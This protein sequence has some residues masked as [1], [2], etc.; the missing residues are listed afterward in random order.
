MKILS[1]LSVIC[2]IASI[3]PAVA[4]EFWLAPVEYTIATN[5]NIVVDLRVGQNFDGAAFAFI[6][7]HFVRF[8]AVLGDKV[9]PV[10]SRIGDRPALNMTLP[11]AGL[12][13]IVHETTDRRLTYQD[14]DKFVQF[15]EHKGFPDVLQ[16][17]AARNLPQ[18]DFRE[19]Y[20]RFVK[21]LIAV[22][23]G[24]GMDRDMGLRT[25]IIALANP[26]TDDLTN[27][28]PVI[29]MFEGAPRTNVQLEIFDRAPSGDVTIS[30]Q[31]TDNQ[32]QAV[33]PVQSGHE[34]NLDAVTMLPLP[35]NDPLQD[36]AWESLWAGLT[37]RVPD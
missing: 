25:E 11:D 13:V 15:V 24:A 14:W 27:G 5:D 32:G 8:E 35:V 6:P 17:H 4:H 19:N 21:T 7:N 34:Y 30:T 20:R 28:L 26:Y 18:T 31:Q 1:A 2:T 23:N 9:I 16:N 3:S 12:W 33:I 37:F 10:N 36:P 29:V 22:G